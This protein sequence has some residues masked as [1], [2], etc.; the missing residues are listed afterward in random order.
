MGIDLFIVDYRFECLPLLYRD[1]ISLYQPVSNTGFISSFV[2]RFDFLATHEV[3]CTEL[4]PF[5]WI[6]CS[7]T[8]DPLLVL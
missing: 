4:C 1:A 3:R 7:F 2:V 6:V 8:F 5:G